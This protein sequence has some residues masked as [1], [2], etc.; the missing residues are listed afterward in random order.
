MAPTCTASQRPHR[1]PAMARWACP[2]LLVLLLATPLEAT[3]LPWQRAGLDATAAAAHLLDRFAFGPRPGEVERV[4]AGGLGAWLDAQLAAGLPDASV[5]RCLGRL[6]Q[7]ALPASEMARR[8]PSPVRLAREAERAGVLAQGADPA[9]LRTDAAARHAVGN[10]ARS[11]GY[12]RQT[13]LIAALYAQKVCRAVAS[14]NQLREVLVDF[15]FG[16]FNVS[17]TDPQAR[18]WVAAY[19]RDAIRP[20]VLG[21]FRDLLEATARHP[22]MLLYL[23]NALSVAAPSATST[24]EVRLDA[25]APFGALAGARLAAARRS[26]RAGAS[27]RA[28]PQGLNENY[29]RELLELHTL[30]VEGGYTQQDVVEVARAFTGWTVLPPGAR[31]D[32]I[33]RRLAQA[34]RFGDLGFRAGDGFLFRADAHDAGAKRVLGRS[35]PAGRGIEDGEEVLDLL[36]RHPATAHHIAFELARRFVADAPPPALVDRLAA[37]FRATDGDLRQVMRSLAASPE[38]WAS[39]AEGGKVKSPFEVAVSALRALGATVEDPAAIVD[40]VARM[41]EPLYAWQA[42]TGPPDTAA[43]WIGTGALVARMNFGPALAGGRLPGVAFDLHRLVAPQPRTAAA[44]LA[45]YGRV[46]LPGRDLGTLAGRLAIALESAPSATGEG[47]GT[48]PS[49]PTIPAAPQAVGLL[50]LGRI[51]PAYRSDAPRPTDESLPARI[52]GLLLGSPE[53]QQR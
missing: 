19:E 52:V 46:L 15:W 44:T 12:R 31:G 53:F 36:A 21:H 38:L 34:E 51:F 49:P 17:L 1:R 25:R 30:G 14:E 10:F 7:L 9:T 41:G 5:E 37:T 45:A 43:E 50:P 20:H 11:E 29:A 23:D 13:E 22:A 16:H 39:V 6:P 33:R 18:V 3:E 2:I 26:D 28:R 47:D 8:Y 35:L 42:P 48:R 32:A 24:L 40:W 27:G 4:A